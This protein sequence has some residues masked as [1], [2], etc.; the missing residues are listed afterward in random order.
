M[1]IHHGMIVRNQTPERLYEALTQPSDLEVWMDAPTLARA[2]VGSEVEFQYD[3]GQFIMKVEIISLE[4]GKQVQ[5]RVIQPVWPIETTDQVITWR[6]ML[7]ES[8]TAVDFRMEGWPQD[9]GMYASVSYKWGMFMARLK[10][11]L[12]DARELED[13]LKK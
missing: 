3:Q 1:D 5:W 2:E 13:L 7:F 8:G 9:D 11:Y 12:G 6:L 10:F 4:P